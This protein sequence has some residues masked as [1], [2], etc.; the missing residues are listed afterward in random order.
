MHTWAFVVSGFH[1]NLKEVFESFSIIFSL[2]QYS[3]TI[4]IMY[5]VLAAS[6]WT[7]IL[8]GRKTLFKENDL[9]LHIRNKL[10]LKLAI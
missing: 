8:F 1:E 7:Y 9:L 10:F 4:I 5:K 6:V 2:E 3:F